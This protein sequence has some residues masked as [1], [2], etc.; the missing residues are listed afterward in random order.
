[1]GSHDHEIVVLGAGVAGLTC[2]LYLQRSGHRITVIDP[3]P[4]ASGTSYGNAGLISNNTVVPIAAPGML[5]KVP[6]WLMD[7]KGPLA[8]RPSYLPLAAPWLLRWVKSSR[9][10]RVLQI[11]DAMRQLHSRS[12]DCWKELLG[13]TLFNEFIHVVG[14][15]R[16]WKQP[17]NGTRLELELCARHGIAV[18]QLTASDLQKMYPGLSREFNVGL[19]I[20][21]NGYTVN[22]QRLVRTIGRLFVD[23]GGEI[24]AEKAMK[25]IPH[26]DQQGFTIMTNIANRTARNVI[27][28]T[29]AWSRELLD[30]LGVRVPLETERGYHAMM[31]SPNI[32][33]PVP[34]TLKDSGFALTSMEHGL[35]AAGTVEIG[36]LTATPDLERAKILV[37]HTKKIFP[38]LKTDK[39][40]YW[41]GHRPSTPDS[42]PVVGAVPEIPGL[43]LDLG[44]G[45]FGMTGGPSTGRLIRDLIND[46]PAGIDPEPYSYLRFSN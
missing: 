41:M 32:S 43:Y 34:L 45:H 37:E 8:I 14:Q 20:S 19:L 2:A 35:R 29:G 33:L 31:P 18:E 30:P 17:T 15:V 6:G 9:M 7:A 44:H 3:Q 5:R 26:G 39:P 1:M 42:L 28:A 22:P 11:S 25:L 24:I 38:G 16:L 13:E 4:P 10:Q 40:V 12:L 21:G 36:G 46:K 27:V 23:A